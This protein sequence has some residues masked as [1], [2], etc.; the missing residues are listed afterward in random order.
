VTNCH[1]L[2]GRFFSLPSPDFPTGFL[3]GRR[4]FIEACVRCTEIPHVRRRKRAW[5]ATGHPARTPASA[6]TRTKTWRKDRKQKNSF[7]AA[8][9]QS[10]D[11]RVGKCPAQIL[12]RWVAR[13]QRRVAARSAGVTP[14]ADRNSAIGDDRQRGEGDSCHVATTSVPIPA[15]PRGRAVG[16][17][18]PR[19]RACARPREAWSAGARRSSGTGSQRLSRGRPPRLSRARPQWGPAPLS[20]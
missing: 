18:Q 13:R 2:R 7:C 20:G 19:P 16:R 4:V 15:L 5:M 3:G 14:H 6:R 1:H 8:K 9:D 12:R 11:H 17:Q 10:P